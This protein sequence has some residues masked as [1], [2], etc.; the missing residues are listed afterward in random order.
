MKYIKEKKIFESPIESIIEET[1]RS[2]SE[3]FNFDKK[4]KIESRISA[5]RNIIHF[6]FNIEN[7]KYSVIVTL[8][9]EEYNFRKNP[10]D[11]LGIGLIILKSSDHYVDRFSSKRLTY[12]NTPFP[13]IFGRLSEFIEEALIDKSRKEKRERIYNEFFNTI[14]ED[15][16]KD[17][18][19][20]LSDIVGDLKIKKLDQSYYISSKTDVGL[21]LNNLNSWLPITKISTEVLNELYLISERLKKFNC[22]LHYRAN[23]GYE[24]KL[25]LEVYP[26][27]I[28]ESEDDY[29]V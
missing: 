20:D 9:D 29:D 12:I 16:L 28:E 24:D 19:D 6:T 14:T 7:G 23:S 4:D 22:N 13:N 26:N 11:Y 3:I 27:E 10:I 5:N 8:H 17:I 21:G 2:L 15:F 18:F 1:K 25:Q